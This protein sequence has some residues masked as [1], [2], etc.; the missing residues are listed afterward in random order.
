[1]ITIEKQDDNFIFN[2][3]GMHKLWAFKS[4]LTIPI[5]NIKDARQDLESI[6]GW[7]GWRAPGTS[8]FSL[9]TAGTFHKDGT[10][11][12]WDVVDKNNCIII[13]LIDEDYKQLIIEVK[14]PKEAINLLKINSKM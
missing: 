8:L 7:K 13:D 3:K 11:I 14:N 2:L 10:K 9:I 4:Q 6:K 12:F 1:M 5:D